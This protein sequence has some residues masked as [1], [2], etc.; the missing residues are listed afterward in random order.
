MKI[1]L[2]SPDGKTMAVYG[3]HL[4]TTMRELGWTDTDPQPPNDPVAM[5]ATER[6]DLVERIREVLDAMPPGQS[7]R[8]GA[9]VEWGP[10]G[11]KSRAV[12]LAAR[13]GH[14][15]DPHCKSCESD[16]YHTLKYLAK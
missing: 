7:V 5:T 16:L 3:H 8:D 6:A 10:P 9:R 13:L 12:Y 11:N 14:T 4:A 15:F 2:R 1:T